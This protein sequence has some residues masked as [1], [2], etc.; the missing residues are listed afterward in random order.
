MSSRMSP[1]LRSVTCSPPVTLQPL[2]AIAH[3]PAESRRRRRLPARANISHSR[4]SRT[5]DHATPAQVPSFT[6][7]SDMSLQC[8]RRSKIDPLPPLRSQRSRVA[9]IGVF[10]QA[11]RAVYREKYRAFSEM[12]RMLCQCDAHRVWRLRFP[13]FT[14][15]RVSLI[16]SH[17]R[18]RRMRSM[19]RIVRSVPGPAA[20]RRR[21]PPRPG[22][23]R[24]VRRFRCTGAARPP[25]R[26][27]W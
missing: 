15:A 2:P 27:L 23:C 19:C 11:N 10:R 5:P 24:G 25:S 7:F 6:A 26:F 9:D 1:T 3:V 13:A 4:T 12:P 14:D 22:R 21:R 18:I 17:A 8:Q 16:K 20:T